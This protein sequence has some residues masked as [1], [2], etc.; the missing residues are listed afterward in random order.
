MRWIGSLV[1][2]AVSGLAI[3]GTAMDLGSHGAYVTANP[4]ADATSWG[5]TS[6]CEEP[7]IGHGWFDELTLFGGIDGSK[8]PQDF[9]V[10]ANLG[11]QAHVNWGLPLYEEWGVGLQL[12]QAIVSSDNAVRVY[13]LL[14]ESTTRFQS[15]TSIGLF[16]RTEQG[17]AWGFT[18]DWLQEDSFDEFSLQQWR[19][20]AAMDVGPCDQWAVSANLSSGSDVGLFQGPNP[21]TVRLS[22]ID[23]LRF[24]WRHWWPSGTQT[25]GWCGLAEG[26]GEDNAVTGP[27][28][29]F[30]ETFLLGADILAP[31]NDRLAIYGETNL[32]FPADSGTVDA[33]LGFQFYPGGGA[34][35]AR[36]GTFSPLLPTAAPTSFSTDL[37]QAGPR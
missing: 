34:F 7:A 24:E 17:F 20:R 14:G 13:E 16:Q 10:N 8:Q 32:I 26:H 6:V 18:Y 15:F 25:T 5:A 4:A 19:L 22:A 28:D 9:G 33:F 1:A 35:R 30:D 2:A 37:T 23:Q 21:V 27:S 31:L 11:G 36:R 3:S 12:G 29:A